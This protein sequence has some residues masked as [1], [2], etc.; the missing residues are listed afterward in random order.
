[1]FRRSGWKVTTLSVIWNPIDIAE[2]RLLDIPTPA[3]CVLSELHDLAGSP[4]EGKLYGKGGWRQVESP[5]WTFEKKY[6][7]EEE[8][9]GSRIFCVLVKCLPPKRTVSPLGST[10]RPHHLLFP[11]QGHFPSHISS[12]RGTKEGITAAGKP[13]DEE[14]LCTFP[15]SRSRQPNCMLPLH[16]PSSSTGC[17]PRTTT[18][19][20]P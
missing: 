1:M 4:I 12:L 19:L 10:Q 11:S 2:C 17:L 16:V 9:T 5:S 8:G 3:G 20:L 15:F 18:C 7:E 6:E 13:A 14:Q